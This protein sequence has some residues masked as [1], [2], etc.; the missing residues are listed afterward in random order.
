[1]AATILI[2]LCAF[3]CTREAWARGTNGARNEGIKLYHAG[4]YAE[5]LLCF[6]EVLA[7][8]GRDLEIRVK[9]GAC[10]LQLNK[11]E[12]ALADF[13]FVNRHQIGASRA[14]GPRGIYDPNST[15][16]SNWTPVGYPDLNFA[17]SWGNRGI[18]L[19]MLDRNEEALESFRTAIVLW[20]LPQNRR[21]PAGRAA[22]YEGLGQ[23]FHRLSND[24]LALEAYDQAI[25]IYPADPNGFAGR[26]EVFESMRMADR[27]LTDYNEAIR[28][29]PAHT[30]AYCGRGIA[31]FALGRDEPAIVDLDKAIALDSSLAKAYSFRGAIHARQSRNDQALAD[32]DTLIRLLPTRAG[33]YK[34]RGGLLVRMRQFD[35]AIEDLD[36]SH[37]T[38]S[39]ACV[40][41][42]ESG[43]GLQRSRSIRAGG[44]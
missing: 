22:A 35:R 29:N 32:Y 19:L 11:P 41:L 13:D 36:D 38:R 18:A 3:C 4:H 33:A 6:D 43:R 24:K 8:H 26:G 16:V 1:M 20:N 30:R 2:V 7:R 14:F 15:W 21:N 9:R 17:E 31:N 44:R 12:N 34:D 10:Y 39:Q 37:K 25:S 27:A 23:S 5:A 28:L 42:S 40:G